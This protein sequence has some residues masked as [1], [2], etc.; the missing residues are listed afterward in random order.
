MDKRVKIF[1]ILFVVIIVGLILYYYYEEKEYRYGDEKEKDKYLSNIIYEVPSSFEKDNNYAGYNYN[2]YKLYNH[3]SFEVKYF[4]IYNNY[5]NGEEYLKDN[6][7]FT[8]NDDVENIKEVDINNN[9]W[10]LMVKN[11][12]S[13]KNYYYATIYN[14]VGYYMEYEIY[15]YNNGDHEASDNFCEVSYDKIISSVRFK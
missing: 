12:K 8:L 9:K 11:S 5:E 1:L 4:D 6:I 2:Y 14:G 10:Y 13:Y 3:C 7:R 15:D